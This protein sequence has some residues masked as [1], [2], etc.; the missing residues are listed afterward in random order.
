M[1]SFV[2]GAG[3][4]AILSALLVVLASLVHGQ[5]ALTDVPA[6]LFVDNNWIVN[7]NYIDANSTAFYNQYELRAMCRTLLQFQEVF[8]LGKSVNVTIVKHG[9]PDV[10]THL[11]VLSTQSYSCSSNVQDPNAAARI[12]TYAQGEVLLS[13]GNYTI[14][15]DLLDGDTTDILGFRGYGVRAAIPLPTLV[16]ASTCRSR[17]DSNQNGPLYG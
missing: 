11:S 14:S 7:V 8:C 16:L 2:L 13:A 9:T 12:N 10:T 3:M 1:E 15:M 5:S 6:A 4:L 17:R